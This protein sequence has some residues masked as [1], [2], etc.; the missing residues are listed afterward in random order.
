[1]KSFYILLVLFFTGSPGLLAQNDKEKV[2]DLVVELDNAIVS[3]D[4][5]K[6]KQLLTNGFIGVIPSGE[7]FTKTNFIIYHTKAGYGLTA[8][9]GH[10]INT[11]TIRVSPTIAIINRR[12]H[13]KVKTPDNNETEF[14]VQHIEICIKENDRWKIAS[15]QGTRV[16]Y[17]GLPKV[18][19]Q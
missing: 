11:A 19:A 14:D 16:N 17:E 7:V 2:W 6:M 5:N 10:D 15:G 18:P 3:K 4:S 13:T 8:L 12:I 9:T 1:M